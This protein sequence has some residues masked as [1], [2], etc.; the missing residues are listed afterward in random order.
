LLEADVELATPRELKRKKETMKRWVRTRAQHP[1]VDLS[2][3]LGRLPR[4][5]PELL[6]AF[7][8]EV[9]TRGLRHNAVRVSAYMTGLGKVQ[10]DTERK[11]GRAVSNRHISQKLVVSTMAAA[12]MVFRKGRLRTPCRAVADGSILATLSFTALT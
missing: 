6:A 11:R 5:D 4:F 10:S 9:M 8:E 2:A 12:D 1:G 3:G 7:H